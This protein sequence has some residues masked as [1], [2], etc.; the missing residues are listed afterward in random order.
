MDKTLFIP[1]KIKVG[2]VKREDTYTKKLAYVIYYDEKGKLR[3]ETSW[4]GWRDK[5]IPADE[6]ENKPHSG[7]VLNKDVQRSG[8]WFGSGRNMIRVYDDRGIEF[9]I[10]CDNLMYILMTTNCV[11]RGL[12][13]AFVYAWEGKELIL[14]PTGCEEYESSVK[15]TENKA[16]KIKA[17]ELVAGCSYK[18]KEMQDLIYLGKFNYFTFGYSKKYTYP[19]KQNVEKMFIF[20]DTN[21]NII[22]F[23]SISSFTIQ[24]SNTPIS[25]YAEYMQ[26]FSDSMQ[27]SPI[28]DL[29][30]KPSF[31]TLEE[32]IKKWNSDKQKYYYDPQPFFIKEKE[33]EYKMIHICVR[34]ESSYDNVTQQYTYKFL[35]YQKSFYYDI[36][37]HNKNLEINYSPERNNHNTIRDVW[38]KVFTS[39]LQEEDLRKMKFYDIFVLMKNGKEFPIN[40]FI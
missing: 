28:E 16:K 10:T 18:T 20:S 25:N 22:P 37:F 33:N 38:G 11:K 36:T 39:Y 2:Y 35:G 6:F 15:Y 12:E 32:F 26:V 31:D 8:E 30:I 34:Y 19:K 29:I 21:K 4:E 5:T 3:K 7:F 1:S 23:S 14:L 40:K 24:N 27:S 13:G 9:E 17:K